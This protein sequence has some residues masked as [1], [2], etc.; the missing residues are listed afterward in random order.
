[1][2]IGWG[3]S[4]QRVA[5][6]APRDN[7]EVTPHPG[8]IR[9]HLRIR[10]PLISLRLQQPGDG[11]DDLLGRYGPARCRNPNPVGWLLIGWGSWSLRAARVAPLANVEVPPHPGRV[12]SYPRI[13]NPYISLQLTPTTRGQNG[14]RPDRYCPARCGNLNHTG[15]LLIGWGS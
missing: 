12:G 8:R 3:S 7:A 4:S 10:N 15:C 1:M 14:D 9:S 6:I 5:R 2:L 13:R 11:N